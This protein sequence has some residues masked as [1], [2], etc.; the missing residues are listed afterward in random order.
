MNNL[1]KKNL[2]DMNVYS[3]EFQLNIRN[4]NI[5]TINNF[6]KTKYEDI[7]NASN[8]EEK[9]NYNNNIYII[10]NNDIYTLDD[11]KMKLLNMKKNLISTTNNKNNI[12][13][14]N[15]PKLNIKQNKSNIFNKTIKTNNQNNNNILNNKN[16]IYLRCC[17]DQQKDINNLLSDRSKGDNSGELNKNIM[18]RD[19]FAEGFND[20]YNEF[21]NNGSIKSDDDDEPDPRINF[22]QINQ[23]NKS[24]PLT[25]YGGLNAR[26]KNLQSALQKNRI[27][28]PITSYNINN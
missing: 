10:N 27:N 2:V 16:N 23:I 26:R 6:Y 1:S 11:E 7:K 9:I 13:I 8:K 24:R 18:K 3:K 4:N 20:I 14:Y 17:N 5:S 19:S 22:E 28:I 21:Q 12:N 25:S 15:N